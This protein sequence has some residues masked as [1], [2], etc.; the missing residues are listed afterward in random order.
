MARKAKANKEQIFVQIAS[1]RDSELVP[2]IRDMLEKAAHP[3]ALTFGICWQ[4][5][6]KESLEEFANDKR[7]R[8]ID[9]PWNESKGLCWARSLIQPLWKGEKW[10][11]QLDSHHRFAENWDTDII[12]MMND[13]KDESPK[14]ILG[15]YA[16][17][18]EPETNKKLNIEPYK[19]VADDFTSHGTILFRPHAI[20]N[21]QDLKRPLRA[22][23]VSGH[24]FFTIGEHC[25]E[26]AYDPHIYFAGDEIS[27][28]IRGYTMGYDL[29]HPHKTLVWHEYLRKH[30]RKH[31]DDH[32]Q[33][34]KEKGITGDNWHEIDMAG[35]VRLRHM[36][37]EEDNKLDLGKYDIGTVRTHAEYERYAGIDFAKRRLQQEA[38]DGKDPPCTYVNDEQWDNSFTRV[39]NLVLRWDVAHVEKADDYDFW[40]VCVEDRQGNVIARNDL[41]HDNGA[42]QLAFRKN[43]LEVKVKSPGKPFKWVLWPH[44]KSKGWLQRHDYDL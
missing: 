18:Y 40:A 25:K 44:S 3:E 42:D 30:R 27:L 26:Y 9:I 2:S 24:F 41:N 11:M 43:T 12:G 6:E 5:C 39:S 10:T 22:R 34:N 1:Y 13:L 23:F 28:S 20:P 32:V 31:W 4:R 21:W 15:S 33:E 8:V 36:L 17:M 16:G 35:K 7:F 19:M 14:A 29:Y 38:V 37:R